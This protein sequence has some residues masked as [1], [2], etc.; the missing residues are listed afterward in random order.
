[1]RP[2]T[3]KRI[4]QAIEDLGYTPNLAARQLKLGHAAAIGIIVPSLTYPFFGH[5]A[6][7]V[8][9][10]AL[11]Y[12]YQVLLANS[13]RDPDREKQVAE[14]LW[15]YGVRGLIFGSSLLTISHLDSLIDKGLHV[16]AFDRPDQPDDRVRIDSVGV[17]NNKVT[18]L[19][20]KHLLSLGHRRIGFISG[21]ARG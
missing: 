7:L 20:C 1:M 4:A 9:K 8:E 13:D 21:K 5:F 6:R 18:R 15:G 3:R 12:G 14:E 10:V 11:S 2:H 19:L 17:D 16:V